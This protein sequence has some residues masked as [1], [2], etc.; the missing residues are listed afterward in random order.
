MKITIIDAGYRG[1]VEIRIRNS[2][3]ATSHGL[4]DTPGR[5]APVAQQHVLPTQL[6]PGVQPNGEEQ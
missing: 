1:P 4:T 2:S 5:A 6:A 3:A